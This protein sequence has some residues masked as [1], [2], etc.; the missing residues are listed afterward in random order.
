MVAQLKVKGYVGR[1]SRC[2]LCS[3]SEGNR[4]FH[5]GLHSGLERVDALKAGSTLQPADVVREGGVFR[6]VSKLDV[7]EAISRSL[8]FK[9]R[10]QWWQKVYI[11]CVAV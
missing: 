3:F 8:R 11:W 6:R 1:T 7:K 10:I 5:R 4:K 2:D 9:D